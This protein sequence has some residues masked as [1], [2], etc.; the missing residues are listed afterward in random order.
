MIPNTQPADDPRIAMSLTRCRAILESH[1]GPSPALSERGEGG[2][3]GVSVAEEAE[4]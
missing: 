2:A 3:T 1:Y 4:E